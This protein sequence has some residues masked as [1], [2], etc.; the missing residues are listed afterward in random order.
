VQMGDVIGYV[1]ATG[2]ATGPHLHYEFKVNGRHIDPSRIM[3]ENPQVPT[4]K[5]DSL[6]RFATVAADL[7]N[8]LSLLDSVNTAKTQ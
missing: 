7:R 5:G 1:G 6:K 4:L 2:W 3:A 8:R